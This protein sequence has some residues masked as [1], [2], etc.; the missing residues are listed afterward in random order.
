[1]SAPLA[2]RCIAAAIV[3]AAAAARADEAR[4]DLFDFWLGDWEARWTNADG[5]PGHGRNHVAK[6]AAGAVIEE[7]FDD[8]AADS[9]LH[10]RSLTVLQRASGTWRQAWADN[11]GSFLVFAGGADGD[12]RV[13]ATELRRDGD[14]VKG[15]RMVFH[16]IAADAFTW[17]WEGTKDGGK[18]WKRLWRIEYRR[19]R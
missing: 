10:G 17:D 5:T 3:L 1:M 4:A 19:Q 14:E 6:V 13:L 2:A 7:Q 16:S 11:Q 9:P 18:T 15:Q 12:R 8:D